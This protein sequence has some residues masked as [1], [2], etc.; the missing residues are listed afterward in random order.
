MQPTPLR[1]AE[2]LRYAAFALPLAMAA[3]PVY[4]HVPKLYVE[5]FGLSLTSVGAAL[6]LCR[7]FDALQDPLI[8]VIGDRLTARGKGHLAL[9]GSGALALA[10]GM[11][12]LFNPPL[13]GIGVAWLCGALVLTYL[14]F[15]LAAISYYAMGARMSPDYHQRTRVTAARGALG[16]LG[17]LLAAALPQALQGAFGVRIGFLLFTALFI[18]LLALGAWITSHVD[19]HL[20]APHAAQAR[21]RLRAA[22]RS[23]RMRWLVAVSILSGI[24]GAIPATLILFFVA[25]VLRLPQLSGLFLGLYFVC[26][27]AAMPLWVALARRWG[28]KRAWLA[29]MLLSLLA[30]AWAF[31]L[32]EGDSLAF[33]AI[34]ALSG[35]AYGAEL[36]LPPSM[37]AD[38]VDAEGGRQSAEATFFGVWQMV[39]KL[40]LA[41]AAGAALPLLQWLGYRAGVP[42]AAGGALSVV[43]ALV[44][45]AIKLAAAACLAIAPL[46]RRPL[47]EMPTG[48]TLLP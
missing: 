6:L 45:C 44:P 46:D 43:Y 8:G 38:I 30:F 35:V 16:V 7:L 4:V 14:G 11:A 9:I 3:V 36:A 47:S 20:P 17:V 34:C 29:G 32:G 40:T 42:Q 15:S 25:D 19:A 48:N 24:A 1:R 5:Q 23:G 26:A 27:A 28:K 21:P 22:L 13:A 12:A 37:L 39:E 33:A 41:L 31:L 2:L 10:L 18:P